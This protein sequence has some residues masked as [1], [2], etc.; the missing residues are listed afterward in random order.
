MDAARTAVQVLCICVCV[1]G[2]LRM[3]GSGSAL[4]MPGG[5]VRLY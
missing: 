2:G 1:V 5:G 4:E 3:T